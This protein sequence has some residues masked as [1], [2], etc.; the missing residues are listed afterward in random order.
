MKTLDTTTVTNTQR[1]DVCSEVRAVVRYADPSAWPIATAIH[2]ILEKNQINF[3]KE[4]IDI[5]LILVG[6]AG[7]KEATQSVIESVK[8]GEV[9]PMRF[10]AAN[11][12]SAIGVCTTAFNFHGPTLAITLPTDRGK[13][14][15]EMMASQWLKNEMANRIF[16]V[17]YQTTSG[18][19]TATATLLINE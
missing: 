2:Q 19:T 9:S 7:P 1:A 12:A 4:G 16:I 17:T 13:P 6:D 18:E 11:A 14:V 10:A 5:G 8:E 3:K 15:A